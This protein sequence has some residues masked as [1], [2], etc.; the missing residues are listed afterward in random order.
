MTYPASFRYHVLSVREREELSF[1]ETAERFSVGLATVKR[2]AR[3]PEPKTYERVKIRKLDPEKLAQD[4]R[5]HPGAYQYE[6]AARFGV[7][8]KRSGKHSESSLSPIKK[9]S[10]TRRRTPPNGSSS[11]RKLRF[12]NSKAAPSCTLMRAVS[13]WINR[14]HT[15]MRRAGN[16]ALAHVTG[17][18]VAG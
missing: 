12:M 7:T 16:S 5:D 6:R 14:A 1:E 17:T 15:A 2:W 18:P 11:G 3:H 4:V 9:P 8:P 10:H 13:P